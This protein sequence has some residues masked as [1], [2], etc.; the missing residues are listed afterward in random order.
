LTNGEQ[1]TAIVGISHEILSIFA[2]ESG[3][4]LITADNDLA[5]VAQEYKIKVKNLNDYE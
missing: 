3:S 1:Y 4:Y 2:Y 5:A